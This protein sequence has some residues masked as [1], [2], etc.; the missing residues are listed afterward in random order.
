MDK[1]PQEFIKEL[2]QIN[3]ELSFNVRIDLINELSEYEGK[4]VP[5]LKLKSTIQ[6]EFKGE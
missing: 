2:L 4:I 5:I 3:E 6:K 1:K